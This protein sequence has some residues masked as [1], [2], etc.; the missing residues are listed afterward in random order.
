MK[1]HFQLLMVVFLLSVICLTAVVSAEETTSYYVLTGPDSS[2][3]LF[4]ESPENP[5]INEDL[6][7]VP[8]PIAAKIQNQ[9]KARINVIRANKGKS[10]LTVDPTLKDMAIWLSKDMKQYHYFS[11][12]DHL[13]RTMA[14]RLTHWGYSYW[15]AGENIAAGY[16]D[17]GTPKQIAK[18][19]VKGWMNSAG[20]RAN[21][22]KNSAEE[23][24][25]GVRYGT[26]KSGGYTYKG[27]IAT[28]DFADPR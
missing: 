5:V 7:A 3:L 15:W 19:I 20:H 27:W 13:G 24:G 8:R 1:S 14:G 4:I 10:S 23:V 11:H 26:V 12:T 18:A 22:L 17:S 9:I 25:I 6:L 28:A 21:I 16:P 2:D